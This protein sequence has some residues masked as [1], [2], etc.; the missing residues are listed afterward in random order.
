MFEKNQEFSDLAAMLRSPQAQ[1]L[2]ARLQQLDPN[3]LRAAADKALQG[4][5][6]GAGAALTP[7]LQDEQVQKLTQTMRDSHGGV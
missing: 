5:T 4:D 6:A 2:L 1:A 3:A 7:L